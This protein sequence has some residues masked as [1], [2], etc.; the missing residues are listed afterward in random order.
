MSLTKKLL[1]ILD[2]NGTVLDSTHQKRP[3]VFYDVKAR[4]KFVYFRP[5]MHDF[6]N[7]LTNLPE[8]DVGIWTSNIR[9]NALVLCSLAFKKPAD[10]AFIFSRSE[11]VVFNDYSS[12][13]HIQRIFDQGGCYTPT[14]IIVVDD[15][16]EKIVHSQKDLFL[17]K[18]PSFEASVESIQNDKELNFLREFIEAK[19]RVL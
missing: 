18:I 7:W 19:L 14:N 3:G 9:E 2:F 15:S 13:K 10:L 5:G 16:P 8:V 17:Y 11:C 6:L 1:V 4:H 12:E